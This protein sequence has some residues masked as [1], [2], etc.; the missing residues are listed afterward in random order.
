[1]SSI[2]IGDF[3][4]ALPKMDRE[5]IKKATKKWSQRT[6]L[7]QDEA[8]S[9]TPLVTGDLQ[10]SG[11]IV[12]AKVTK[13]GIVSKIL[14]R[15]PY[16]DA[17]NDARV[18]LAPVGTV[19]K[20]KGQKRTKSRMG[21]LVFLDATVKDNAQKFVDDVAEIIGKEFLKA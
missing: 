20:V 5:I 16:A 8:A 4:K 3:V 11:A 13:K 6:L 15:V 1:M 12:R 10:G 18:E 7:T 19:Y 17:I 21:E 14:F 9:R 2:T